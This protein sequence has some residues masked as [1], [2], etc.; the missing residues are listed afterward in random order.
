MRDID[1]LL[2]QVEILRWAKQRRAEI[3]EI[4]DAAKAVVQEA[5][6]DTDEGAIGGQTVVTWKSHKRTALDSTALK[7][8]H[9]DTYAL[10]SKTTEVRRFE[11][12][13]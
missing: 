9:P 6:G 8:E 13:E 12:T 1:H 2:A 11:V 5:L 7:R 3:K 10:Y 4:E